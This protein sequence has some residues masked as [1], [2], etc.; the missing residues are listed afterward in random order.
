MQIRFL[1]LDDET[2]Y[3]LGFRLKLS[4]TEQ[5]LLWAIAQGG[6]CDVD[7]LVTLLPEGVKRGN[8]AVHINSINKK[9]ECISDRKLVLFENGKYKI[10]PFM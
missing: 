5:K 6:K 9:A 8:V 3:L 10:N 4:R 2:T 7:S 1:S